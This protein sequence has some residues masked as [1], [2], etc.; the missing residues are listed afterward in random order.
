MFHYRANFIAKD[1]KEGI[2]MTITYD[3]IILGS[4]PA[5][6]SAGFPLVKEGLN[7]LMLDGGQR[8][9]V[10][11][12]KHSYLE[13]RISD[14]DQWEWIVGKQFH[15]LQ[16]RDTVSPKLRVPTLSYVFE[17]F[18]EANRIEAKDFIAVGSLATGG[19][20]NAWGC[21]VAQLRGEDLVD[22]PVSHEELA[23]SYREVIERIGVSAA[24]HDDLSSYFGLDA[25]VQPPIA[26]DP[27]HLKMFKRYEGSREFL[28]KSGFR[29][30]RFPLAALSQD[31]GERKG[32]DLS[33]NCLFGCHRRALYSANE[34]LLALARYPNFKS[35]SLVVH[36]L[37]RSHDGFWLVRGRDPNTN[38]DTV[39]RSK[40]VFLAAGTLATT[41]LALNALR[42]NETVRLLSCP[43][44]AFVLCQPSFLGHQRSPAFGSAQLAFV[45]SLRDDVT[46]MGSTFS[47][48]GLPMAEFSRHM[49]LRRR[50][51][52]E[53]LRSL[54]GSCMVGNLFLP[55]HLSKNFVHC[56]ADGSLSIEG[57]YQE[58][59]PELLRQAA[60]RLR[61]AYASIGAFMLPMSFTP[62][63]PGGDIHYAGTLPMKAQPRR[64]ETSPDGELFSLD[65]VYV[66][67]GAALPK[68]AEKSHTLTIMAN[69]DRIAKVAAIRISQ[70]KNQ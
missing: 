63:Q 45:L 15:A 21:G 23:S 30:G 40:K 6:V 14:R 38:V 46:A 4:G 69:A 56:K 51:A 24:E 52:V 59:V 34:D 57:G 53:L 60:V 65:G 58:E 41:R 64:G 12:P 29:L 2:S 20:S 31:R 8:P 37:E 10:Y 18:R 39:V 55:G 66:V 43:T 7:V 67:D 9:S 5:G 26:L 48:T 35:R 44:A 62:G 22:Y 61:R 17:G 50:Y 54:M 13:E 19:M 27:L 3:A 25:K 32:C 70:E 36:D 11:P 42:L 47:T 1:P 33:S 68:L 49:P 28:A 16:M